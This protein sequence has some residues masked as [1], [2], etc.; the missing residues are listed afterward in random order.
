M[1]RS[2]TERPTNGFTVVAAVGAVPSAR[3]QVAALAKNLGLSMSDET[4]KTVELLASELIANAVLHSA[5][6][7]DVAVTRTDERLRVEV[8]DA[9]P[10]LPRVVEAGPSDESGRGLLLVGALADAWGTQ[11]ES[12]GKTTW[13]EIT[14]EPS[15]DG[16]GDN[17]ADSPSSGVSAVRRTD[18]E[19]RMASSAESRVPIV[20][21][22]AGGQHQAA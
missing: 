5:A 11:P 17:S 16:L 4:L 9:N 8:T 13:F 7:C 19:A 21:A 22:T 1:A 2:K 3:R 10:S 20:P 18:H 12:W 15:T 14:P 6:P